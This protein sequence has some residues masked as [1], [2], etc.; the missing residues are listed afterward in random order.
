MIKILEFQ[1]QHQSLQQYSGLISLKTEWFVGQ[2]Q[3]GGG[4]EQEDHF[5]PHRFIK[6]SFECWA[7]STKKLLNAGRGHQAPRKEAHSLWKEVGQ[8]NDK[9]RDTR[10]RDEM[11]PGE[12]VVKEEKFPNSRKPSHWWVCGEF[13]NLRGQHNREGENTH[14]HTHTHTQN[15]RLTTTPSREVTQTPTSTA[16]QGGAGC[17]LRVRTE[18]EC[19][20]DNLRELTW[21]SNPNCGIE[22]EKKKREFSRKRLWPNMQPG[23]LREQRVERIPKRASWLRTSPSPRRRQR[24]KHTNS[25]SQ[26]TRGNLSSE[27]ASSTKLLAGSQLLTK[28]SWDPGWLIC[29]RR[30]AAWDQLPKGDTLLT[31]DSVLMAHLGNWVSGTREVNKMHYPPETVHWLGTWSPEL[32]GPGKGTKHM[33]NQ[34]SAFV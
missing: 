21:D 17:M 9:K 32:P 31:W 4:I 10:V 26:K 27:T 11:H 6:R 28:S 24:G 5:L 12:G 3:V 20:E 23:S 34:V 7:T 2:S 33:P 16:G 29:A 22:R 13:W 1:L 19:P 15:T 18:S 25:Q 30:A 8:R 14:T